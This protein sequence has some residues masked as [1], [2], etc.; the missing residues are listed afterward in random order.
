MSF[1]DRFNPAPW[2]QRNAAKLAGFGFGV[3]VSVIGALFVV[4]A[5]TGNPYGVTAQPPEQ[6]YTKF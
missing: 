1:V 5:V 3:S 2:A 4:V 6:V